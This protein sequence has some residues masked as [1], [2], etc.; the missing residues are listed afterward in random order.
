MKLRV[1]RCG[2]AASALTL[3]LAG[4]GTGS[5]P[6]AVDNGA[7]A[8]QAQADREAA[9]RA[10]IAAALANTVNSQR[11]DPGNSTLDNAYRTQPLNDCPRDFSQQFV[12]TGN[13]LHLMR[14]AH[15][16][17]DTH[18]AHEQE[19]RAAND[20][21]TVGDLWNGKPSGSAPLAE[22]L[23][24]KGELETLVSQRRQAF[25]ESEAS[26]RSVAAG[27]GVVPSAAPSDSGSDAANGTTGNTM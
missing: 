3:L 5:Q 11:I 1:A 17:L 9:E 18:L 23:T 7:V 21:V 24:R 13:A 15:I 8:N 19:A 25:E 4:C 26:L 22:W 10:C 14:A 27:Y 2:V 20:R 16:D 12:A 6:A